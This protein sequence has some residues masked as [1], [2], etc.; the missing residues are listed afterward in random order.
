[1]TTQAEIA[2]AAA[3]LAKRRRAATGRDK[4]WREIARPEQLPPEGEWRTWLLLAGR[5]F[6]K[7]RTGSETIAEWARNGTVKMS[8]IAAQTAADAR[9]ISAAALIKAMPGCVYEPSKRRLSWHGWTGVFFSAEDPDSFRGYEFDSAWC[10]EVAAWKFPDSY[11]QIQYGLRIDPAKQIITTTP[12]PVR[13][14]RDLLKSATTVVTRGRT[15]DNKDN[16][17]EGALQYLIQQYHGTRLGRQELEGE[18][19]DDMPGALWTRDMFDERK[20]APELARIVVAV[21]PAAS[22][23]EEADET[24]IIVAGKGMDGCGYVLADRSCRATPDGWAKR[25]LQAWEEYQADLIVAE[26]NNGGE[27]VEAVLRKTAEMNKSWKRA[28]IRRIRAS[29]G[30]RARAE[31]V[32]A[33]YEQNRVFHTKRFDDLEDQLCTWTPESGESPDRL[34]AL[35]WAFTDLL[36]SDQAPGFLGY[37]T[38]MVTGRKTE[39]SKPVV[40]AQCGALYR[41]GDRM[42]SCILASGHSGPH[43]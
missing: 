11:D 26:D 10:D 24:G 27:M 4:T 41:L 30:K 21:D 36:V 33:L 3:I 37:L 23:S 35:V 32:S 25:A 20:P 17:S 2:A 12:R 14:V 5:G 16:L 22:S 43:E 7:T 13:I 15:L 40:L 34:D 1:M 6:G 29:R 19:L 31:P 38:N 8:C 28:P 9:D 18:V 42:L 39:Q